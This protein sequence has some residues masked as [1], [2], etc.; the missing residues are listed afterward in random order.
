MNERASWLHIDVNS[1]FAS[2]LQ[3]EN[4]AL[5]GRPVGV[6]KADKR[7]CVITSSKEAKRLGVKT[8]HSRY[9]AA[10]LA[11]GIIFVPAPFELCLDATRRLQRVI[12]ALASDVQIFSLD[13][14]FVNVQTIRRLYPDPWELARRLQ[15]NLAAELGEWVTCN[16][17]LARNRLLAKLAS[18]VAPKGTILE[19]TDRN[20]DQFLASTPFRNVCG[21]GPRLERRLSRLGVFR[22]YH[23]RFLTDAELQQHFGPYW[24]VELRKIGQ[25][26]EPD[27]L[28]RL[29]QP[30]THMKSVGRTIT[31]YGL[32]D[33]ER[34][35]KQTLYNLTEE[36]AHKMRQMGMVG[37]RVSVALWGDHHAFWH[38]HVT[39]KSGVRHTPEIFSLLY[40]RLY[41]SWQRTFPVIK[42]GVGVSLL[43]PLAT[44][45]KPLFPAWH[46]QAAVADAVDTLADKYGLFTVKPATLL[47]TRLIRPEVTGYLGD[48]VYH[49]LHANI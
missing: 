38:R 27:I 14:S 2:L 34:Q 44:A 31:G 10:R 1:Y 20:Q 17:G 48:K 18:E 39:L 40:E 42:F 6:I 9:E 23:L 4:P 5:R 46:R 13:E 36:A 33:D 25:G 35:I 8:G 28:S 43:E 37:R 41:R 22:P 30:L 15:E 45:N 19:I 12:G 47:D 16:V 7:T 32:C 49:L 3:Q 21:V 11:P 29:D 24:A 26:D